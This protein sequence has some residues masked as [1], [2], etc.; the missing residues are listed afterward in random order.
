MSLGLHGLAGSWGHARHLKQTDSR[1]FDD[2]QRYG[3][4]FQIWLQ[5]LYLKHAPNI[6]L[7][8]V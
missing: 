3:A 2:Y 8:I 4:I 1:G 5:C 6:I 7:V